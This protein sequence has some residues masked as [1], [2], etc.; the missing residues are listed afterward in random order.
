MTGIRALGDQHLKDLL[1]EKQLYELSGQNSFLL[2]VDGHG[3][4]LYHGKR[5]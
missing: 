4:D 5:V 3:M 1:I 2:L